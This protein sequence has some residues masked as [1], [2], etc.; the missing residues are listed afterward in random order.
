M[1]NRTTLLALALLFLPFNSYGRVI[2][3]SDYASNI[4]RNQYADKEIL[5]SGNDLRE[6]ENSFSCIN[7]ATKKAVTA[8]NNIDSGD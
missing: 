3:V 2:D 8:T 7:G 4:F 5:L 1:N 6:F